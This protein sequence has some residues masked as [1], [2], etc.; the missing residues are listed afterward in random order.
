MNQISGVRIENMPKTSY[1]NNVLLEDQTLSAE[2]ANKENSV[3]EV[4]VIVIATYTLRIR[5]MKSP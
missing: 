1:I 5:K 4:E 2:E 3:Y